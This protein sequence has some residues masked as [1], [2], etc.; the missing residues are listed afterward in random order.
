MKVQGQ[1]NTESET[2]VRVSSMLWSDGSWVRVGD[3][4]RVHADSLGSLKELV[5]GAVREQMTR[6]SLE[7]VDDVDA[8]GRS[9]CKQL[10]LPHGGGCDP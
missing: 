1:D 6:G 9:V 5:E 10:T 2:G 7:S 4:G 8:R 3:G